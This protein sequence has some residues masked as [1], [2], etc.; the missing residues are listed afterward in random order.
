MY[1]VQTPVY[2]SFLAFCRRPQRNFQEISKKFRGILLQQYTS[3]NSRSIYM[4]GESAGVDRAGGREG[5]SSR[6]TLLLFFFFFRSL[7]TFLCTSHL[8]ALLA[9]ILILF[10]SSIHFSIHLYTAVYMY[11]VLLY[12]IYIYII[13]KSVMLRLHVLAV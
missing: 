3:R 11:D 13:L 8:F 1:L 6:S 2:R 4:W 7:P 10:Y 12:N 5:G 9:L